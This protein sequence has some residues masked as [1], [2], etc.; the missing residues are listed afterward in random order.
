MKYSLPCGL[1][2]EADT[3][4]RASKRTVPEQHGFPKT[5]DVTV[6][7]EDNLYSCAYRIGSRDGKARSG[8]LRLKDGLAEALGNITGKT[9]VLKQTGSNQYHLTSF[10][11]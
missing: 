6:I 4:T 1:R 2:E 9:L 10:I 5:Y 3:H 8:V 11:I 7:W